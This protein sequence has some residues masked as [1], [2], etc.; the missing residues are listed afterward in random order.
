MA[1]PFQGRKGKGT[2]KVYSELLYNSASDVF[3][4]F[5]AAQCSRAGCR[6]N[7]TC[8]TS[9]KTAGPSGYFRFGKTACVPER[10]RGKGLARQSDTRDVFLNRTPNFGALRAWY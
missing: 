6:K 2:F 9:A 5:V 10:R 4:I 7:R 3:E 1:E 8:E